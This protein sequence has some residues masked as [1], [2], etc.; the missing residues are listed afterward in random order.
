MTTSRPARLALCLSL[1]V[2]VLVA[3]GDGDSDDRDEGGPPTTQ[4]ASEPD[5]QE[6]A[7]DEESPDPGSYPNEPQFSADL[8]TCPEWAP[9]SSCADGTFSLG[10]GVD[11]TPLPVPM[12][13]EPGNRGTL[14]ELAITSIDGEGEIGLACRSSFGT[15]FTGYALTGDYE[16]GWTLWRY[17]NGAREL[18]ESPLGL[19]AQNVGEGSEGRVILRLGCGWGTGPGEQIGLLFSVNGQPMDPVTPFADEPALPVDEDRSRVGIVAVPE[20][21]GELDVRFD[22]F[23]LR[24]A[25]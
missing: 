8:S 24:L 7:T 11:V 19:I 15:P 1:P 10:G 5:D 4:Q 13:V 14:M 21:P 12:D 23:T 22:E 3:C 18:I 17:E 20:G 25:E 6:T 16:Q 9:P 2:A